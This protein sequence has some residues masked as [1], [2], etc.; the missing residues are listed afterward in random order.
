MLLKDATRKEYKAKRVLF[1]DENR[2]FTSAITMK[3]QRSIPLPVAEVTES[4]YLKCDDGVMF[5]FRTLS[6]KRVL[7]LVYVPVKN[8]YMLCGK[9][10]LAL[11]KYIHMFASRWFSEREELLGFASKNP[12]TVVK[13]MMNTTFLELYK[14]MSAVNPDWDISDG[15]RLQV[16]AGFTGDS[17][18]NSRTV[19]LGPQTEYLSNI[20]RSAP[21][22][23]CRSRGIHS[24]GTLPS[25]IKGKCFTETEIEAVRYMYRLKELGRIQPIKKDTMFYR[26]S[27]L[28]Q[29]RALCLMQSYV[30]HFISC[31]YVHLHVMSMEKVKEYIET[32]LISSE[33]TGNMFSDN[34]DTDFEL[35]TCRRY[36]QLDANGLIDKR[37]YMFKYVSTATNA[38][39]PPKWY[40]NNTYNMS[41]IDM[42]VDGL[43]CEAGIDKR[44]AYLGNTYNNN[45]GA[46]SEYIYNE[47]VDTLPVYC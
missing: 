5:G 38:Q 43:Y 4:G 25:N 10:P 13:K 29:Y 31:Q 33:Y 36:Y 47:P 28:E 19:F 45:R 18:S 14:H 7:T 40:L 35:D 2:G 23:P 22:V 16:Y 12:K 42:I 46:G 6:N 26:V 15:S 17:E 24:Q 3:D 1:T 21:Q 44:R 20:L 8:D 39:C 27:T 30:K 11:Y 37:F 34:A 41:F 9:L 32:G